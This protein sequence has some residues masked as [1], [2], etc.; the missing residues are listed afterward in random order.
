MS[1]VGYCEVGLTTE[2]DLRQKL[3]LMHQSSLCKFFD[4]PNLGLKTKSGGRNTELALWGLKKRELHL[5]D[6]FLA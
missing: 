5:I 1:L 3:V 4:N 2:E 6:V